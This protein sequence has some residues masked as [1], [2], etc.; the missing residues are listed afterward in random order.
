MN[1]LLKLLSMCKGGV[2]I[3]ADT[4]DTALKTI[5]IIRIDCYQFNDINFLSFYHYD[6]VL[7]IQEAIEELEEVR[8]EILL[9]DKNRDNGI[10][11]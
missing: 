3:Y 7:G 9:Y 10:S 11:K 8:K 1:N 5:N 4:Y 6:I 2:Q